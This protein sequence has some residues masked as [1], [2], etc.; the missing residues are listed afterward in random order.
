MVRGQKEEEDEEDFKSS[1]AMEVD[2]ESFSEPRGVTHRDLDREWQRA[3]QGLDPALVPKPPWEARGGDTALPFGSLGLRGGCGRD[4]SSSSSSSSG[5]R[6]AALRG[7]PCRRGH[8][9]GWTGACLGTSNLIGGCVGEVWRRMK[10]RI[11]GVYVGD[12][13]RRCSYEEED[14]CMA[15]GTSK[16]IG[17]YVGEEWRR[18]RRGESGDSGRG[19]RRVMWG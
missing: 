12:E 7:V 15:H 2:E 8:G 9:T 19:W 1:L 4:S 18:C 16:S 14:T 10:R 17:V 13:W 3:F 6:G 5:G 11:R